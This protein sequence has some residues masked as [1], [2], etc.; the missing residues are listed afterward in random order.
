LIEEVEELR[1]SIVE[2]DKEEF[3]DAIGD[4]VVVLT[5]LAHLQG[6][7]IEECVNSAYNVIKNRQGKMINGSFVKN[8]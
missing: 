8:G 5:N 3:I 1:N 6:I 7:S 4:C 2:K